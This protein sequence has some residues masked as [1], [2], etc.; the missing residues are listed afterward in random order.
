MPSRLD[1]TTRLLWHGHGHGLPV[2]SHSVLRC[3]TYVSFA[4]GLLT[5]VTCMHRNVTHP[6]RHA[7]IRWVEASR[8]HRRGAG[9]GGGSGGQATAGICLQQ[10]PRRAAPRCAPHST[11]RVLRH[12]R[13]QGRE[14]GAGWTVAVQ[15]GRTWRFV[16]ADVGRV[17]GWNELRTHPGLT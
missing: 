17:D 16:A 15:G 6:L 11:V 3:A 9:R 12:G 4:A 13:R 7:C 5:P 8:M 10:V 14:R 1:T 2:L